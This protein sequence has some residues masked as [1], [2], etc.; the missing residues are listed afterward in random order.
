MDHAPDRRFVFINA[1]N[2]W[3]RGLFLEPD[4]HSGHAR[5]NETTRTLLGMPSDE[6]M[7]RI[8]VIVPNYRHAKYLHRRLDSIYNQS[9]KNIEVLLLD[10]CSPDHSRDILAEYQARYP[11]IT[12]T[13][14]N[15]TNSGGPFRQWAKGISEASGDL[16]WIAESD[17]YCE[18][19]FLE[20]LVRCFDDE[21]VLLAYGHSVFVNEA[22]EPLPDEMKIYLSDL[23]HAAKWEGCYVDTAHIEVRQGLGIKNTIPNASSVLFRKPVDMPL[24]ADLEWLSMSVA[25]DWVFYLH[26]IRGGKVAYRNDA[27]NFFR[28]Y[29]GSTAEATYRKEVFYREVGI[30]SRTVA[31]LYDVP[32][33]VLERCVEG[34]RDFYSKMVNGPAH[35]FTQWYDF[36]AVLAARDA[37]TPA[38]LVSTMGFSPGGAEI[39]PIRMANEFKRQ[40]H[41]VLLL[42]ANLNAREDGIRRMLRNDVPLVETSSVEETRDLIRDFGIEALNSHQWHVQKYPL[43]VEDVF[44]S[45]RSHVASLHGMIEH[46]EAFETTAEQVA[47]ANEH[48][49]TWV[50]TA[51]K[52]LEPFVEFG[53][54]EPATKFVKIPNGLPVPAVDVVSRSQMNIPDDAFVLCCV[55]R[56]IPDK[57]WAE[58]IEAVSR[59]RELSS[60]DIRLILVGNGPVYD[61]YCRSTI[62]AFVH[63]AG[64][65][66]NSG[67][68]YAAA[69]MGIML[70]TFK[71]E[72]F[73]LTIIDCLFS[74]RPY[75]ASDVGDIRN[76]L[77][78]EGHVAGEVIP[79]KKW[80]VQ[81]EQV[82]QA[83]ATLSSD[84]AAYERA[85]AWVPTIAKRYQID[86]VASQYVTL[87]ENDMLRSRDAVVDITTN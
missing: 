28:R 31:S 2:D 27:T 39:L 37:R 64:F 15:S 44:S 33:E 13:L 72:S 19:Q 12:R 85:A 55:S 73:P 58:A 65:S 4:Q 69:D 5:L 40:G 80:K 16:I 10:D 86:M 20:K 66:K 36:E 52:N 76:M 26:V 53:L 25:G 57:G 41:S 78:Y 7:P 51:D 38:I 45:L 24:L 63:L 54:Y 75:I 87:F 32:L 35:D 8:T 22:E 47:C 62:P 82:A 84:P 42:S 59:A 34:Y 11:K 49:T 70:T 81:I 14:Y 30:A 77:T 1:W 6:E 9:Y 60:R 74:G 50:Y 46:G 56:A 71:S 21:A 43:A 61:A 68:Y 48:V 3:N 18:E 79:L 23:E 17:D 83:I 67:G 29:P